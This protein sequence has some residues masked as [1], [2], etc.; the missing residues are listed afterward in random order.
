MVAHV[1]NPSIKELRKGDCHEFKASVD[2][3]VS[4]RAALV[5]S[6]ALPQ[7]SPIFSKTATRNR[8]CE[9]QRKPTRLYR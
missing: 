5:H 8:R 1:Y 2:Y 3:I 4:S 7:K 6:K 9:Q